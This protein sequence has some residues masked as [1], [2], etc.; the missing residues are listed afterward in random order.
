MAR[1]GGLEPPTA[2]LEGR[3]TG[4]DSIGLAKPTST[5]RTLG[6]RWYFL[7]R[8]ED[9]VAHRQILNFF[10]HAWRPIRT[11]WPCF[12][13][14]SSVVQ[15]HLSLRTSICTGTHSPT[16]ISSLDASISLGYG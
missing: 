8:C 10:E 15:G 13:L 12:V 6:T 14:F 16:T 11:T 4:A 3:L 9:I 1:P 5:L 7:V 2:G